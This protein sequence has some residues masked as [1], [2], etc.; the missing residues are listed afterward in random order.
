MSNHNA[1]IIGVDPGSTWTGTGCATA[2]RGGSRTT[3]AGSA[4]WYAR[5]G[6]RGHEATSSYHRDLRCQGGAAGAAGESAA[7]AGVRARQRDAGDRQGRRHDAGVHGRGAGDRARPRGRQRAA[8]CASSPVC[9]MPWFGRAQGRH[10]ARE[11]P[12]PRARPAPRPATSA[13]CGAR[14]RRWNGASTS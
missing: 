12:V 5:A 13:T 14:S 9:A 1:N 2:S 11:A 8:S 10:A 6:S 3:G 4:R 7:G